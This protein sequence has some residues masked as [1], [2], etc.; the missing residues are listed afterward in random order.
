MEGNE[1]NPAKGALEEGGSTSRHSGTFPGLAL[2]T[3]DLVMTEIKDMS[4]SEDKPYVIYEKL[5]KKY[6]KVTQPTECRK[7]VTK[8]SMKNVRDIPQDIEKLSRIIFSDLK[9]MITRSHSFVRTL[10]RTRGKT[11]CI[12]LYDDE[13]LS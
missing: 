13:Q 8:R 12:L 4:Q 1:E 3:P 11:P 10:I 2:R 6:D 9:N 5:K 7:Y